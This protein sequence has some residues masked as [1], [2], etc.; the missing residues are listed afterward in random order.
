MGMN[1]LSGMCKIARLSTA[2]TAHS[3]RMKAA[4]MLPKSELDFVKND[5][6]SGT[7]V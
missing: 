4:N 7:P 1:M 5:G 3:L 6:S 2:C